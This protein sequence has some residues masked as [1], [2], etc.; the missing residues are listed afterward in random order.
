VKLHPIEPDTHNGLVVLLDRTLSCHQRKRPGNILH[1]IENL[2]TPASGELLLV[3]D[4]AQIQHVT[5]DGGIFTAAQM[6]WS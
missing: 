4:L 6:D 5:L 2:D 1:F 3:V